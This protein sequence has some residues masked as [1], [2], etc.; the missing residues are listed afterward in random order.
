MNEKIKSDDKLMSIL[1]H[2]A[3]LIPN[4]G[5]LAPIVIWLTQKEKSKFVRYNAIQAIFFQLL[6]FILLMLSL[7]I[8]IILMAI[9]LMF[10]NVSSGGEPGTF[11]WVSMGIM[12]LYFPLW[13]F[14][15]IYAIVAAVKSYR[16]KIF[17]YLIIGR[18]VE[19]RVYK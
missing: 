14:F 9:S 11:F 16:G 17:R 8:G 18:I 10:A 12:N 3:I 2:L 7:F 4:I 13:F 19:K 1:S 6:F 5:I 15:S